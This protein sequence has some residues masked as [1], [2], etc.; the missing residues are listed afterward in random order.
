MKGNYW[1]D[2]QTAI[3]TDRHMQTYKKTDRH[4]LYCDVK[5]LRAVLIL[6]VEHY[7]ALDRQTDSETYR[8]IDRNIIFLRLVS[9]RPVYETYWYRYKSEFWP[10]MSGLNLSF[11]YIYN[12]FKPWTVHDIVTKVLNTSVSS[13]CW[14][15]RGRR[16]FPLTRA[17][18]TRLPAG[19][20]APL[21]SRS[22][23]TRSTVP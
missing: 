21:V 1:T 19:R 13:L 15:K 3:R 2:R 22:A 11:L 18:C 12:I 17:S 4:R 10:V 23:C 6:T 8:H 5:L 7:W 16:Q 20:P 14:R 9:V